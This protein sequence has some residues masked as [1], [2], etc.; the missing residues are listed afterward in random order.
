M[1]QATG[2]L[3]QYSFNSSLWLLYIIRVAV[4]YRYTVITL[5]KGVLKTLLEWF[6]YYNH[7]NV[8]I[9]NEKDVGNNIRV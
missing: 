2:N 6:F 7:Q 9:Y 8:E 4:R 1:Q 5:V 3:I